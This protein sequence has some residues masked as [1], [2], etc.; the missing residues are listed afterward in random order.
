MEDTIRDRDQEIQDLE[1]KNGRL[2]REITDQRYELDDLYRQRMALEDR[3][4]DLD[5]H[6]PHKIP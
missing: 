6:P 2:Q 1:E 3:L 5:S 4:H